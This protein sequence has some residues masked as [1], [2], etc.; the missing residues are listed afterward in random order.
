MKKL[1]IIIFA[2]ICGL[3][4]SQF[5]EF[6]Q[7]YRQRL[8]GAVTELARIVSRFDDDAGQ[9]GLSRDEA[10]SR[11]LASSDEFLNL[12]GKSM[13]EII[14]RYDYLSAHEE[15][16]ENA[17]QFERL[18]VFARDRDMELA[19]DTAG[20]YEPAL[21]ITTEGLAHAAGGFAGGL[22]IF[23]LLLWPFGRRRHR[24]VAS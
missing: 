14:A 18:W 2:L 7:Q 20:I 17:G 12:R 13:G 9:F 3:A 15:R 5:P 6:E 16:L 10:L 4:A 21:P 23:G 19:R 8:S 11:Y 1:V 22:A 24:A